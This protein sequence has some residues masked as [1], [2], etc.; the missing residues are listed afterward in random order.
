MPELKLAKLPDRSP[1][2]I[3]ITVRPELNTALRSYA[4]SYREAYGEEETVAELIPYML[5]SFLD[6][7]RN[8]VK[9][10]KDKEASSGQGQT[11][12]ADRAVPQRRRPPRGES[13]QTS[14]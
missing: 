6:S 13:L 1:V 5:Q 10:L 9:A 4:E 14:N 7:D 3:T 8:F 2:K 12:F 11:T